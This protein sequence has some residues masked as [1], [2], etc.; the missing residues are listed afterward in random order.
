MSID[1]YSFLLAIATFAMGTDAFIVAGI[2][3]QVADALTVTIGSAG[4]IV[5]VFS[6][7]Y[8]VSAPVVSVLTARVARK[9][10]LVGALMVFAA[11]NVLSAMSATLPILLATRVLAALAAGMVTPTC[12]AIASGLGSPTTRGRNLAVTAAGFTSAMVLGVPFGVYVSRLSSWRGSFGFVALLAFV[13]GVALLRLPMPVA[14]GAS[15]AISWTQQLRSVGRWSTLFVLLPFLLWAAASYGLYT[16]SAAILGQHL[17]VNVIPILLSIFGVGAVSGNVIGGILSDRLG[18]RG[19]TTSL[20]IVLIATL[21]SLGLASQS[22]FSA[23]LSMVV[24]AICGSGLFTLQQQRAMASNP[25]HS[26]FMLAL[27]NSALYFGASLGSAFVGGAISMASLSAGPPV[28]AGIAIVALMLLLALPQPTSF[29][30]R[31]PSVP[32]AG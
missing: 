22:V 32:S 11:A 15:P 27:N 23:A 10:I 9:T 24:W 3:P 8:A 6:L 31:A 1:R 13:A 16:Y 26:S 17:S 29:R 12:Y 14:G 19:P 5:S 2:L 30:Q 25:Q 7:S 21:A 18:I 20:A 4:L 28:S